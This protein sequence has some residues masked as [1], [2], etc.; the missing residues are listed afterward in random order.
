MCIITS[1]GG[2]ILAIQAINEIKKAEDRAKELINE[3]LSK[4]STMIKDAEKE[5]N[6]KYESILKSA[7]EES[8]H[9]ID[10]AISEG[11]KEA[12]PIY[13]DGKIQCEQIISIDENKLGK[14]VN[15]IIEKVVS[16]NGNS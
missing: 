16:V 1:K 10:T 13:E 8:K 15:L 6:Q 7:N 5:S 9:I 11:E 3:A 4:K 12:Q 14:A 2:D